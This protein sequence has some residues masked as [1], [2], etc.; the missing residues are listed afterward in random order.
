MSK[1]QNKILDP[2]PTS[3]IAQKDKKGSKWFQ[4]LKMQNVRKQEGYKK[5]NNLYE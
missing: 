3:E 4:K 2:K 1:L 5:V